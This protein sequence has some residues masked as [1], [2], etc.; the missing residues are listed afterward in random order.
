MYENKTLSRALFTHVF[1]KLAYSLITSL[2]PWKCRNFTVLKILLIIINLNAFNVYL[3][4][5]LTWAVISI[6]T[7]WTCFDLNQK[8]GY[9]INLRDTMKKNV[10]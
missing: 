7:V 9:E 5:E 1:L 2:L 4:L 10:N 8:F 6:A 3:T